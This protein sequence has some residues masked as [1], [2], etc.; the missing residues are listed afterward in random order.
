MISL[1]RAESHSRKGSSNVQLKSRRKAK[2]PKGSVEGAELNGKSSEEAIM[3]FRMYVL[4]LSAS[5]CWDV[6]NLLMG[7]VSTQGQGDDF[8]E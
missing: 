7:Y 6:L 2:I 5:C 8:Q 4:Q 3:T 1:F